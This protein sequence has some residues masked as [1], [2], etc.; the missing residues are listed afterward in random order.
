MQQVQVILSPEIGMS[1]EEFVTAWNTSEKY[2]QLAQADTID[3][4]LR[5]FGS[6]RKAAIILTFLAVVG[7]EVG[8]G[9]VTDFAKD[10]VKDF[11]SQYLR[12]NPPPEV[13]VVKQADG[14]TII[15]ITVKP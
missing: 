9:V 13:K 3:T 6:A 14:T 4:Q 10:A 5:E 2:H 12:I 11:I 1:V 8:R 7:M 15:I